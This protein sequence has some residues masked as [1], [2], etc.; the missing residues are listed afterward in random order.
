MGLCVGKTA[1]SERSDRA[2][3]TS[4]SKRRHAPSAARDSRLLRSLRGSPA[5][6]G[7][8]RNSPKC[9][10]LIVVFGKLDGVSG[11][12]LESNQLRDDP[13]RNLG[14]TLISHDHSR[15]HPQ[16]TM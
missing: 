15:A 5:F 6:N 7:R 9:F 3:V 13:S 14:A 1:I 11:N 16:L 12:P 2:E 4:V 8:E 10:Y